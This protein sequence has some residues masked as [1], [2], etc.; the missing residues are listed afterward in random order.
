LIAE[1]KFQEALDA[2]REA[3]RLM[4]IA[5]TASVIHEETKEN[6]KNPPCEAE[7]AKRKTDSSRARQAFN[8]ARGKAST[9]FE[10]AASAVQRLQQLG[11]DPAGPSPASS[12]KFV[13]DLKVIKECLK[14][15]ESKL[16]DKVD[17]ALTER[18][19]A[20][21]WRDTLDYAAKLPATW[22]PID[23]ASLVPKTVTIPCTGETIHMHILPN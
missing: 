1:R 21:L 15:L 10:A 9:S 16:Y 18:Q 4:P 5:V 22:A 6:R 8:A 2:V 17:S 12:L 14:A 7:L 20:I 3:H 23:A 13:A 19:R 11:P